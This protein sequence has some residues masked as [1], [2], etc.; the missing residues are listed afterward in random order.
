[1]AFNNQT[2]FDSNDAGVYAEHLSEVNEKNRVIATE[3]IYNH[4]GVLVAHQGREID[5]KVTAQIARHKLTKP[6]AS[7][8][9]IENIINAESLFSE[10][11][12]V[13]TRFTDLQ[14]AHNTFNLDDGIRSACCYFESYTILLQKITVMSIQLPK[15]F[16]RSIVGAWLAF[17]ISKNMGSSD[18]NNEVAFIAGLS[19]DIG[20]LHI[21]PKIVKNT[22][23]LTEDQW[24][25][26]QGHVPI[27]KI[28]L[29]AIPDLPNDIA[30]AV[31]Q[32]HERCDGAGYP[33]AESGN[34][35]NLLGQVVAMADEIQAI[36]CKKFAKLGLNIGNL[37]GY[38]SLNSTTHYESVYNGTMLFIR[39]SGVKPNRIIT[40]KDIPSF[41][42]HILNLSGVY[43][44][45][46]DY[47]YSLN[48]MLPDPVKS[49]EETTIQFFSDRVKAML[50]TSGILSDEYSRWILHVHNHKLVEAYDE[51]QVIGSMFDELNWQFR[52][53]TKS[54]SSL[55]L[56][57]ELSTELKDALTETICLFKI[58]LT[59]SDVYSW[60]E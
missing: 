35:L 45:F 51:I 29:E 59:N 9:A 54:L 12:L 6:L 24:R 32:H 16:E 2:E 36:R 11:K 26:I 60:E 23:G 17:V 57:T 20:F 55:N 13:L 37:E 18:V 5:I 50:I 7:V 27:S 33:K 39:N 40:D 10:I 8:V 38:L 44:K 42:T 31:G 46:S 22:T 14:Q 56:R 15:L 21:D 34:N 43:S 48:N 58:G 28:L 53:I 30:V 1:M 4:R 3:D 41:I 47:L 52:Y 19:R 49:I 25:S